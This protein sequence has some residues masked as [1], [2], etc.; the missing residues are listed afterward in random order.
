[1]TMDYHSLWYSLAL[2]RSIRS[3]CKE[4]RWREGRYEL[5]SDRTAIELLAGDEDLLNFL[6]GKEKEHSIKEKLR[7][8]EQKWMT[9]TA[10]FL[11]Y[12]QKLRQI[13][14]N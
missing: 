7:E 2:I 14:F 9:Q 6:N 5:G 13:K 10:G 12:K 11:L 1:M 8:E 3:E 4:F